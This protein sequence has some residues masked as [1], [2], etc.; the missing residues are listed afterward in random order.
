MFIRVA[1]HCSRGSEGRKSKTGEIGG[2]GGISEHLYVIYSIATIK[3]AVCLVDII[4]DD[5][6]QN[7]CVSNCSST[8]TVS[9]S[10]LSQHILTMV[11]DGHT[12][13]HVD[14]EIMS[15]FKAVHGS[16]Q[17]PSI[18]LVHH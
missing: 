13:S 12:Y 9:S 11:V 10:N 8:K 18:Y 1:Q 6:S 4:D 17:Q 2:G 7:H 14:P 5:V 16:T 3:M 15:E